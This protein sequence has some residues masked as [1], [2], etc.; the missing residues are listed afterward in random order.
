MCLVAFVVLPANA[1][2]PI[3]PTW[4]WMNNS[5]YN[6][7]SYT[8]HNQTNTG[9]HVAA[10]TKAEMDSFCAAMGKGSSDT[11][12]YYTTSD[13]YINIGSMGGIGWDAGGTTINQP[14]PYNHKFGLI[15]SKCTGGGDP[16]GNNWLVKISVRTDL[17]EFGA[18][19]A[20]F[21]ATPTSGQGPL[22]VAFQDNSTGSFGVKSY[23]WSV[24]PITGVIGA[25]STSA[26]PTFAFTQNG[27]YSITH[28]ISDDMGS[29]CETKT[30]Y[31][32]VYN[33]SSTATTGVF[34]VDMIS[35]SKIHDAEIDL[36][37]IENASWTN[38]TGTGG[39]GYITTLIGHHLN[40]YAS[41]PGYDSNS[42]LNFDSW[43]GGFYSVNLM[44]TGFTSV[45][46]G[47]VTLY[48]TVVDYHTQAPISGSGVSIAK[49]GGA[50]WTAMT[51][52]AGIASFTVTNNTVY[53][54]TASKAGYVSLS[55][56][57]NTGTGSGGSASVDMRFELQRA[58]VTTVPTTAVTT[59]PGGGTPTPTTTVDPYTL[60]SPE[61]KQL[62]LAN[63][64]LEYGPMLIQLFIL[65]I[66][67]G[68]VK[69]LGK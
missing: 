31:I 29:D 41:A 37:D 12:V 6:T 67:V 17:S 8:T 25:E 57:K 15:L 13:D 63:D 3:P 42:L 56:S 28:C 61:E 62:S 47:N 11:D 51:N 24:S 66:V 45:S 5:Y 52:A 68:A 18:L 7:F 30:D 23:N 36:Y 9:I 44:P 69:M 19:T 27:N 60:L 33:S 10:P 40:A 54:V 39:L 53:Y 34:A 50:T 4:T 48:V 20:D 58:A 1:L 46:A 49:A 26:Y 22:Y 16:G 32:W 59:L 14:E 55:Q 35:G 2:V 43:G 65:L 38:S 21:D 64:A